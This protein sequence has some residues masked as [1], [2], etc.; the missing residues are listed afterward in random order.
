MSE[1][2]IQIRA[3]GTVEICR[4]GRQYLRVLGDAGE[5]RWLKRTWRGLR[6]VSE[7]RARRLERIYRHPETAKAF[8][9]RPRLGWERKV[10]QPVFSPAFGL[11]KIDAIVGNQIIVKFGKQERVMRAQDLMTRAQAESDWHLYWLRGER[12]RLQEGRRLSTIKSLCRHGEWQAFLDKYDYARSTA[13]DLIRR[14]HDE[15]RW[16][17]RNQLTGNRAIEHGEPE[18]LLGSPFLC[19]INGDPPAL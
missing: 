5:P 6:P 11:G 2:A 8:R 13:D 4:D 12:R 19:G 15:L 9:R 18:R 3:D 7:S 10:G 14:Y 1:T 17:V 16:E